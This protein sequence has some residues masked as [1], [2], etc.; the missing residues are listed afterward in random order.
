MRHY[1]S[2]LSVDHVYHRPPV[3]S[4]TLPTAIATEPPGLPESSVQ[5]G[6]VPEPD[7][8]EPD[9]PAPLREPDKTTP[10]QPLPQQ[11]NTLAV[12]KH[13]IEILK[14]ELESLSKL[15]QNERK[16]NQGLQRRISNKEKFCP[17]SSLK[18]NLIEAMVQFLTPGGLEVFK[19]QISNHGRESQGRRYSD[20]MKVICFAMYKKSPKSYKL[21]A[22]IFTLPS[23]KTLEALQRA[24]KV[25]VGLCTPVL[26][27]MAKV[28][29][30]M[31][32]L[33]KQ[34]VICLD[35]MNLKPMATYRNETDAIEGFVNYG[36]NIP[37]R[38]EYGNQGL[39]INIHGLHTKWKQ[40]IGF[41]I[42]NGPTPSAI[43]YDLLIRTLNVLSEIGLTARL[44]VCDQGSTNRS[45]ANNLL[46]VTK[47]KPYFSFNGRKIF[48]TYDPPH[49]VKS[50][51][52]NLMTKDFISG[53]RDIAQWGHFAQ[54]F[55]LDASKTLSTRLAPKLARSTHVEPSSFKKMKV[56]YATQT[57]SS[58]VAAAM[59]TYAVAEDCSLPIAAIDTARFFKEMDTLFDCFNSSSKYSSKPFKAA[60]NT[61][62]IHWAFLAE[63]KQ[64]F[65]EMKCIDGK[66]RVSRPPCFEGWILAI[67][68]LEQLWSELE[69]EGIKYLTTRSLNQDP[70]E[71]LFG[72]VRRMGADRDNPSP[73]QFREA[74]RCCMI[75]AIL[76]LH[77]SPGANCEVDVSRYLFDIGLV[78]TASLT[79]TLISESETDAADT[80]P[81]I[82]VLQTSDDGAPSCQL[83]KN[84]IM[85][86]LAGRC[87]EKFR[88]FHIDKNCQCINGIEIP[89][90][91]AEMDSQDKMYAY[92][93]AYEHMDAVFGGLHVPSSKL[94]QFVEAMEKV[95]VSTFDGLADVGG[96]LKTMRVMFYRE[97][98]VGTLLPNACPDVL[99]KLLTYYLRMRIYYTC[100][101]INQAL[102]SAAKKK[103]NRKYRKIA[104]L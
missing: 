29:P 52:N 82:D 42:S 24:V 18:D 64:V 102:S 37:G 20:Q 31:S 33:E 28:V 57:F 88:L 47:E 39:V 61:D 60:V 40:P 7:N 65:S 21:W 27:T 84:N 11:P 43:L 53:D 63:M 6:P 10:A 35:E 79:P 69:T 72:L 41:T 2:V 44:V 76:D 14:K 15:Y 23:E 55:D 94:V 96:I 99:D 26:D 17:S 92:M 16:K 9:N 12:L 19:H 62:S 85:F 86:Y 78:R 34:T 81:D 98:D 54:M 13:H 30:N 3:E 70:L 91:E 73:T 75:S 59:H 51:R 90:T 100:K 83:A 56:K 8:P 50:V 93:K 49:L 97:H 103:Q 104:H 32:D 74:L 68:C 4:D 58:T 36:P 1:I 77:H 71:N 66:H 46:K 89:R 80:V 67:N 45:M 95:F 48:F 101:F 87:V 38:K 25:E 22:Q 5:P